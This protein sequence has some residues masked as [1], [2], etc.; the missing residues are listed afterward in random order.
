VDFSNTY[1]I[2]QFTGLTQA[3]K[4]GG[5][6]EMLRS[7]GMHLS[8]YNSDGYSI[9]HIIIVTPINN[10]IFVCRRI[11]VLFVLFVLSCIVVSNDSMSNTA[12]IL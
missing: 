2:A 9:Y 7:G 11:I 8:S 5:L 12:G 10:D 3:I 6:V 1:T 4:S